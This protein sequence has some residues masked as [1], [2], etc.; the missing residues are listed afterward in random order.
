MSITDQLSQYL[1]SGFATGAIYALIGLGFSIIYN[2]TGI[3]NFAQ[4]EFVMLGGMFSLL[5]LSAAG[6][7]LPFA[8]LGAI[9]LTTLVGLLFE[10]AA[11][12]RMRLATA[13]RLLGPSAVH[14]ERTLV[15]A[16]RARAWGARGLAVNV[17]TVDDPEEARR[18]AALGAT[19]VITNVPGRIARALRGRAS[20]AP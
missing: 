17:W 9:A 8:I 13:V 3:I 6:L 16:E 11:A 4:G 20:A 7:P 12:W 18:L 15:T 1:L 10:R 14:P 5:L 2:A 19:A